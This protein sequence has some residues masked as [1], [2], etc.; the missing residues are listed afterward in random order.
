MHSSR[1]NGEGKLRGKLANPGL[2]GKM[3]FKTVCT[4]VTVWCRWPRCQNV[5]NQFHFV[6]TFWYWDIHFWICPPRHHMTYVK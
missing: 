2:P 6:L 5:D 3:A 1:I 4:H